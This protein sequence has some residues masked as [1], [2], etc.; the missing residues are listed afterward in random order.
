MLQNQQQQSKMK[1]EL[2]IPTANKKKMSMNSSPTNK[3]SFFS[4]EDESCRALISMFDSCKSPAFKE[5]EESDR[6]G[7]RRFSDTDLFS[8]S[9]VSDAVTNFPFVENLCRSTEAQLELLKRFCSEYILSPRK[10]E[11][12]RGRGN[13]NENSADSE[14]FDENGIENLSPPTEQQPSADPFDDWSSV[15]PSDEDAF[16]SRRRNLQSSHSNRSKQPQCGGSNNWNHQSAALIFDYDFCV[17][18]QEL[19]E[20][21]ELFVPKAIQDTLDSVCHFL[22]NLN[23]FNRLRREEK[24]VESVMP[25]NRRFCRRG[26][27]RT[28]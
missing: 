15:M 19:L 5:R 28:M 11:I 7:E 22:S 4:S 21:V 3:N 25:I 23:W 14:G 9:T 6:W 13:R 12:V 17:I 18:Q 27:R 24:A 1:A 20:S 26:R 10:R 16:E 2:T 8:Q